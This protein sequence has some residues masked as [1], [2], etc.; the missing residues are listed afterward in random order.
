[1]T[2]ANVQLRIAQLI[3]ANQFHTPEE[4]DRLDDIDPIAVRKALAERGI[5]DGKSGY[6]KKHLE[7]HEAGIIIHKAAKKAFDDLGV[8]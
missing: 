4:Y 6:S 3:K 1:M 7:E 2:R 8:K 5:V